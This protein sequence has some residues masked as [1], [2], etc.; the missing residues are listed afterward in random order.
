MRADPLTRRR[1]VLT[2]AVCVTATVLVMAT[3]SAD[4]AEEIGRARALEADGRIDIAVE[5]LRAVL[6]SESGGADAA[7]LLELA[8]LTDSADEALALA[9]EALAITRDAQLRAGAHIMR[10]DYL[11]AAGQ[12][13]RAV[14]EYAAA[15]EHGSPAHPELRRAASLLAI[16]DIAGAIDIYDDVAS[17]DDAAPDDNAGSRDAADV[18]AWASIGRGRAR[19]AGGDAVEAA[20]ELEEL[21]DELAGSPT[22]AHALAAAADAL[23]AHGDLAHARDLLLLVVGEFP[24][25]FE[26]TLAEDRVRTIDRHLA[27]R[28]E[29]AT[30]TDAAPAGETD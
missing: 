8:R 21:A 3:A 26:S 10:G 11:Y 29:T 12:Y 18:A 16:G 15:A 14:A 23:V 28:E 24:N 25:T 7:L 6:A 22:R 4:T 30:P 19:L 9:D 17:L 27:E 5:H 2:V 20:L 1:T 13:G